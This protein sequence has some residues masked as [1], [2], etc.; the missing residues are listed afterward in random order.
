MDLKLVTKAIENAYKVI[1]IIEET[2]IIEPENY[3]I[4]YITKHIKNNFDI[5]IDENFGLNIT[6]GINKII[7]EKFTSNSYNTL[8]IFANTLIEYLNNRTLT[9][10]ILQ[11]NITINQILISYDHTQSFLFVRD[12]KDNNLLNRTNEL[13]SFLKE[14]QIECHHVPDVYLTINNILTKLKFAKDMLNK[15]NYNL[16]QHIEQN[17]EW[18]KKAQEFD[19]KYGD[20][21]F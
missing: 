18:I 4:K 3:N 20:I 12:L 7:D 1:D 11:K 16:I 13:I 5:D 21:P 17:E 8:N 9:N 2:D 14:I 10:K 6:N 19:N 15:I